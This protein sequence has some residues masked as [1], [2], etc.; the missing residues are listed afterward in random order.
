MTES[1]FNPN[2]FG[3]AQMKSHHI[4]KYYN[5]AGIYFQ[6]GLGCSKHPDCFSCPFPDCVCDSN[7]LKKLG[8]E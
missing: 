3:N 2:K 4:Q 7:K 5:S 8:G 1:I 6:H